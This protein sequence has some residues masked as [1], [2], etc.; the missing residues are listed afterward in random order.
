[1]RKRYRQIPDDRHGTHRSVFPSSRPH[2]EL[3][4]L[5]IPIPIQHTMISSIYWFPSA[6]PPFMISLEDTSTSLASHPT[7]RTPVLP[8]SIH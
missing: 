8:F 3:R 7:L 4:S 2:F 1:M 6:F 5:E